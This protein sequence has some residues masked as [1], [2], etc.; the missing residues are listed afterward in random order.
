L[1][2]FLRG[3]GY[4]VT[5]AINGEIAFGLIKPRENKVDQF[6][7]LIN[8][9]STPKMNGKKLLDQL[10][11]V[12]SGPKPMVATGAPRGLGLSGPDKLAFNSIL[13]QPRVFQSWEKLLTR[14]LS[15]LGV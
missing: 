11:S 1:S 14:L 3:Q 6:D 2:E 5:V 4:D 12:S 15:L 7:L 10:P 8:D 9:L 13:L